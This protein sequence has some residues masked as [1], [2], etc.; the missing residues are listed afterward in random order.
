MLVNP[1]WLDL[2]LFREFIDVSAECK[3]A[4]CGIQFVIEKN[5]GGKSC[6]LVHK[7]LRP[8]FIMYSVVTNSSRTVY[9]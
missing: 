9:I 3:P 4:D 2:A 5:S 8:L 7:F 6:V 1:F